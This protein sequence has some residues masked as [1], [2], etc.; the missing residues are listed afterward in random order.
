[1]AV[2]KAIDL[3]CDECGNIFDNPRPTVALVRQSARNLGWKHRNGEDICD[4]CVDIHEAV[5]TLI[6]STRGK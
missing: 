6:T 3:S 5:Q 1:M 2:E 4:Q